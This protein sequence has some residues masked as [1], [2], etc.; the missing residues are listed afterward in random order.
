LS[1]PLA[2]GRSGVGSAGDARSLDRELDNMAQR[3]ANAPHKDAMRQKAA[4]DFDA[5]HDSG[6]RSTSETF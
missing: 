1:F 3:T 5:T 2:G 4:D 6:G